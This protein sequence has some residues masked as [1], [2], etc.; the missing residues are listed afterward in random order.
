VNWVAVIQT[1]QC[2]GRCGVF[3]TVWPARPGI[4]TNAR[5]KTL[6]ERHGQFRAPALNSTSGGGASALRAHRLTAGS[7]DSGRFHGFKQSRGAVV[8]IFRRRCTYEIDGLRSWVTISRLRHTMHRFPSHAIERLRLLIRIPNRIEVRTDFLHIIAASPSS[9]PRQ[10]DALPHPNEGA[11]TARGHRC[12]RRQIQH[13]AV[14]QQG[15]GTHLIRMCANPLLPIPGRR[16]DRGYWLLSAGDD[17]HRGRWL[18]DQ[19]DAR[20]AGLCAS[21]DELLDFLRRSSSDP[22]VHR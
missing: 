2:R 7:D 16:Y 11:V 4:K 13:V 8:A 17:I 21:S 15:F 1:P 18:A 12:Y 22:R 9:A 19:M 6:L 3:V 20:G 5:L 10:P 14:S